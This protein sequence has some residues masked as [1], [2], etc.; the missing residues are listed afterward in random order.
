M[1]F[2]PYANRRRRGKV[3][4]LTKRLLLFAAMG[5]IPVALSSCLTEQEIAQNQ[6]GY[7]QSLGATGN[8]LWQ[9]VQGQQYL[10]HQQQQQ[11]HDSLNRI[12]QQNRVYTCNRF[13][14]MTQC[15]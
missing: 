5:A 7:C 4:Q 6:V 11:F 12:N 14:T 10:R 9:C 2:S 3:K 15:W 1:E 13:G 8:A